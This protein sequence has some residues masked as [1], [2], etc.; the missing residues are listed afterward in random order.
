MGRKSHGGPSAGMTHS[1]LLPLLI[2]GREGG[3]MGKHISGREEEEEEDVMDI[4][5]MQLPT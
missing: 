2:V 4:S 3:E 1:H 5:I